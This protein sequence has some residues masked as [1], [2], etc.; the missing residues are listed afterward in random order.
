MANKIH[1][2]SLCDTAQQKQFLCISPNICCRWL[3]SFALCNAYI[4]SACA[5]ESGNTRIQWL[6]HTIQSIRWAKRN[7]SI[8]WNSNP[9]KV[10]L[11]QCWHSSFFFFY[12]FFFFAIM[13]EHVANVNG[14]QSVCVWQSST[15]WYLVCVRFVYKNSFQ[16]ECMLQCCVLRCDVRSSIT[17]LCCCHIQLN[18]FACFLLTTINKKV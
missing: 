16:Y 15:E 10:I 12:C 5:E 18:W 7:Q 14:M 4:S 1:K 3:N 6:P 8:G 9:K 17:S 2:F 11:V 13:S